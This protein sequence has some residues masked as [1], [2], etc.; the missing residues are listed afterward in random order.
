[1]ATNGNDN[2]IGLYMKTIDSCPISNN[3]YVSD[4]LTPTDNEPN[5][6]LQLRRGSVAMEMARHSSYGNMAPEK[7]EAKV[8]VIYTGGTIGMMRN[9][10]NGKYY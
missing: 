4:Q 1:M 5:D 6:R 2:D 7:N 10:K 9:E 8:L 3:I